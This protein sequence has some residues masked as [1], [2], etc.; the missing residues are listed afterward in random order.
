[1]RSKVRWIPAKASL[2]QN[3]YVTERPAQNEFITE[4]LQ[5]PADMGQA[6]PAAA[7]IASAAP[8]VDNKTVMNGLLY[9]G[10]I[11]AGLGLAWLITRK[12]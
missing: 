1:V 4:R 12:S 10:V 2:G 8:A 5:A 11:L 7:P 3:Q 9:G 6:I